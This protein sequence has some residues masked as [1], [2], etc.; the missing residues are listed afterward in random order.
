MLFSNVRRQPSITRKAPQIQFPLQ[1]VSGIQLKGRNALYFRRFA[2]RMM[3]RKT[4]R[5]MKSQPRMG[6][7]VCTIQLEA[8]VGVL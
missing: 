3:I 2:S 5:I 6:A 7:S 1:A 4:T 8:G